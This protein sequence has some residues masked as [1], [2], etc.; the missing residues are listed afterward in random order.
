[1]QCYLF[2]SNKFGFLFGGGEANIAISLAYFGIQAAHIT[3]FSDTNL[4]RAATQF[5]RHHWIDTSH[6]YYR[7][8]DLG[9]YFLEKGA[10]YRPSEIIYQRAHSAFTKINVGVI[11]IPTCRD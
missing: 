3:Q 6:V 7:E 9:S 8:G 11:Y 5:L 4:G 1:M 10:V 2:A